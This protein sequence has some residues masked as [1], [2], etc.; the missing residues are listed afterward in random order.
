MLAMTRVFYVGCYKIK[1]L[2]TVKFYFNVGGGGR[3]GS[4]WAC[5]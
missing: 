5:L 2:S 4:F 1:Q 3:G